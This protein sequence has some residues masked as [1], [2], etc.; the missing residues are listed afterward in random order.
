MSKKLLMGII[1]VLLITNVA[2]L[3][4]KDSKDQVVLNEEDGEEKT[5]SNKE[6]VASIAGEEIIYAD[7]MKELRETHGEK[8]L[9]TMIDREIVQQLAEEKNIEISE[10]VIERELAY[11]IAMQG[12]MTEDEYAAAE[13][14]WR[15]EIIYRYQLEFLLT[16]DISVPE[17]EIQTYYEGYKNQYNMSAAMQISHILVENMDTAEKVYAELEAGASFE[18]LAQE[19]SLDEETNKDGGYLGFMNTSSQFFPNGYEEVANE[20]E[21]HTYSEP[22]VADNGIAIIYLQQAVPAIEFDYEEI[23]DYVKS[24]LALSQEKMALDAAPLW[25]KLEVDWIFSE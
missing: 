9:K 24:E 17:E 10:K 6:P 3:I 16:E 8:Q 18:L 21:E 22:F 23:K 1:A 19:Y 11:L 5:V 4:F 13:E 12:A 14:K 20:M 25:E 15:E 2:T 7:W